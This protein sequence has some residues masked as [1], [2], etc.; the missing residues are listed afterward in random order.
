MLASVIGSARCSHRGGIPIARTSPLPT[1]PILAAP[2]GRLTDRRISAG[3]IVEAATGPRASCSFTAVCL[4]DAQS[5]QRIALK[6]RAARAAPRSGGAPM[7]SART[8][9]FKRL[10]FPR[11]A[12]KGYRLSDHP[13]SSS[14]TPG[15]HSDVVLR[16]RPAQAVLRDHNLWARRPAR[17]TGPRGEHGARAVGVLRRVPWSS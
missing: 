4:T 5:Y 1:N 8:G 7:Y 10:M 17:Q 9:S 12:L 2:V 11:S 15:G 16:H 6:L 3:F 13:R 14:D